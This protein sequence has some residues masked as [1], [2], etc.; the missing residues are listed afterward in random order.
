MKISDDTIKKFRKHLRVL[1][2]EIAQ[3]VKMDQCCGVSLAQCHILME[4]DEMG[5]AK[6]TDLS[7]TL[8]LDKSTLSRTVDSMVTTGLLERNAS[9]SD[10]RSLCICLSKNGHK[11]AE[12]I[13]DI[14]NDRYTR[15]LGGIP[16]DKHNQVV[17]SMQLLA[18]AMT[19]RQ[20]KE[21]TDER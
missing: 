11:A 7:R 20:Q 9:D 5:E 8:G 19:L 17:E 16:D 15:L 12:V 21:E 4:L 6:L 13:N 10:R 18:Q 1:E 2:R 3:Q 14:A